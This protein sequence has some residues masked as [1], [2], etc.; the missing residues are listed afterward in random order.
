MTMRLVQVCLDFSPRLG[1]LAR[2]VH[3][4]ASVFGGRVVS[5]DSRRRLPDDGPNNATVSRIDT[6]RG[7]LV[8]RH[9]RLTPHA[10]DRL[11]EALAGA[12][13]VICHSLYRAHLPAVRTICMRKSLPY[14]IITHGMLD[15]WVVRQR[16]LAKRW[17]LWGP[18]RLCL[19]DASRVVFST[20]RERQKAA[21]FYHGANTAVVSWPVT[22]PGLADRVSARARMRRHMGI[23]DN[24]RILLWL[25]RYDRLKRPLEIVKAFASAKPTGWRLIMAGYEGDIPR[26][27][28]EALARQAGHG[29]ITI[30]GAVEG[31]FKADLLLAADAFVS[32]SWREN[33]G[34]AIAEAMAYGLPV[35]ISPDHDLLSDA[36]S[37]LFA[38]RVPDHSL[39]SAVAALHAFLRHSPESLASAGAAGREWIART[40]RPDEFA[41][42]LESLAHSH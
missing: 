4:I 38:T 18:G 36:S 34:Y 39:T 40:C 15:P 21:N 5:L 28:V 10:Y 35:C 31:G 7:P 23:A 27:S 6:G 26:A 24:D 22:T 14:W 25:G 29:R 1:G 32:L 41:I 8:S 12:D 11:S 17:W 30:T 13:L 42:R 3:D 2:G 19:R 33:F 16:W 37:T 9:L 20:T